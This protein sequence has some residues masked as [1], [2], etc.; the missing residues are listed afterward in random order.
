MPVVPPSSVV[1]P[2]TPAPSLP[3]ATP[4]TPRLQ[5]KPAIPAK[6]PAISKIGLNLLSLFKPKS[7]GSS[8]GKA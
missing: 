1:P 7:S 3:A 2:A 4:S 5:A 6:K 8:T